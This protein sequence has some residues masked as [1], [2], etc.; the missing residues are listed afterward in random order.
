MEPLSDNAVDTGGLWHANSQLSNVLRSEMS[1]FQTHEVINRVNF[2]TIV[3]CHG[4]AQMRESES[5][6]V[7]AFEHTSL[8]M[9]YSPGPSAHLLCLPGLCYMPGFVCSLW[10]ELSKVCSD[11]GSFFKYHV[12]LKLV[13]QMPAWKADTSRRW[14]SILKDKKWIEEIIFSNLIHEFLS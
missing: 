8:I 11:E 3:R 2:Q 13:Q 12:H 7:W 6:V 1:T 9:S 4:M 5:K 14:Y 10:N